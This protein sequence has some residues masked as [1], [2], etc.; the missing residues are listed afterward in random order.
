MKNPRVTY[1]GLGLLI[2][3]LL[4]ITILRTNLGTTIR[5]F[6]DDYDRFVYFQRGL[7]L[8][9]HQVPFR[10][11]ISEY[12][13]VPTYLFGL[14]HVISI[15]DDN[16][17]IAY[18]KYSALFSFVML[19]ILLATIELLQRMLPKGSSL[20]YLLLLPAPLFFSMN[21]FDILP[22]YITLLSFKMVQDKNWTLAGVLLG[23]G[24]LTKWY[25]A[26]LLPAFM[27]Y[28]FRSTGRLPWQMVLA[29]SITCLIIVLPTLLSG[30]LDALSVPYRF[31]MERS[32]ETVSLPTLLNKLLQGILEKPISQNVF[33]LVFLLLQTSA[34][35]F[36]IFVRMDNLGKLLQSCILIVSAFVLFSRIYS[37][38]WL[39]WILP[40]SILAAR[41]KTD[42]SIL[43][44][45]GTIT[46]I[47]FPV[48]WDHFGPDSNEMI[49]FGVM[50]IAFLALIMIRAVYRIRQS[51][52]TLTYHPE[53]QRG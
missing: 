10:D 53:A 45:Y 46:Y 39:L 35:P 2:F 26:L 49:L 19:I 9:N 21:R 11:T 7:W 24:A 18:W 44:L 13:Q 25:P 42:I 20:A 3:W 36:L 28:N 38:Q 23:I 17:V 27:L 43:A 41:N 47:G 48:V 22:A 14:L 8:V 29:F 4:T 6:T 32:M 37:P 15:D 16:T 52:P 5:F 31:H 34:I 51:G 33:V 12:P 40:F 1:V 50:N 30:G